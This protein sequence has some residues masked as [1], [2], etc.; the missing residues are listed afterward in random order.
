[1]KDAVQA[2]A[3]A[4]DRDERPATTLHFMKAPF[5]PEALPDFLR[6]PAVESLERGHAHTV[7]VKH[8][9]HE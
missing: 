2:M 7:V 8:R 5:H 3:L 1:M 9:S 6:E 4:G